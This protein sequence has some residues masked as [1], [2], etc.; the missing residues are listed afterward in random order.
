MA[1][2]CLAGCTLGQGISVYIRCRYRFEG[3]SR[4]MT[5]VAWPRVTLAAI[6]LRLDETKLRVQPGGDPAAQ[7]KLIADKL[8]VEKAQVVQ[9]QHELVEQ[10]RQHVES[11]LTVEAMFEAWHPDALVDNTS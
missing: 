9:Q 11:Q 2:A 8:K 3:A 5:L 6:R 1:V 7:R 10:N 4:E